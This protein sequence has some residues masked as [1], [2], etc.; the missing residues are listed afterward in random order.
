LANRKLECKTGFDKINNFGRLEC[1][2]AITGA[3]QRIAQCGK[4][5]YA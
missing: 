1:I 3:P 4:K 2:A 5:T